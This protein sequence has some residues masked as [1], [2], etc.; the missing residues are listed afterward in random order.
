MRVELAAAGLVIALLCFLSFLGYR[1]LAKRDRSTDDVERVRCGFADGSLVHPFHGT[2][3]NF[4]DLAHA[5]ALCC[6]HEPERSVRK[7]QAAALEGEIGGVRK[8]HVIFVLCD[9]MG[10]SILAQH[11]P[12]EAFLRIHNQQDRLAAVFPSTTPAA[13]TTLATGVW[14]GQ[15][16]A[17]GWD[18]RDQKGCEFPAEAG[19]GPVQLRVLHKRVMDMRTDEP[20][21][22]RGFSAEE[23]FVAKPWADPHTSQ[24]ALLFVNAYN[25]TEFPI[26]YRGPHSNM[27][28]CAAD[29]AET[30]METLGKPEGSHFAVGEFHRACDH[31][32]AHIERVEQGDS[33]GGQATSFSYI[34]T[35]HPDKHMHALGVE[36]EEVGKVVRGLNTELEQLWKA[37]EAKGLDATLLVTADHGHVTVPPQSMVELSAEQLACL[38]YANIHAAG[39][40]SRLIWP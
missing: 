15:H 40:R 16:G 20:A 2:H 24:R 35:A 8:K 25:Q 13:L 17:P 5:L 38:E 11:L 1:R 3:A 14:P 27:D 37:L 36:H 22:D 10:T 32:L 29:I 26:W 21:A 33:A 39:D 4:T 19:A 12:P 9:G 34:Y 18:L 6:G 23:V 30:S 31:V 28:K 7:E